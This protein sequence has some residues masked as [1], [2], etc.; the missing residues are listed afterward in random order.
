MATPLPPIVGLPERLD[1]RLRLGPFPSAR[2]ALKF[3]TY[4]A[5]GALLIPFAGAVAW[6]PLVLVAFAVSVWR[7]EGESLDE[8]LLTLAR[9]KWRTL[10]R[11]EAVRRPSS[12]VAA[13]QSSL[14]LSPTRRAAVLKVGGLPLAYLP[15]AEL[16]RRF[17]QFRELLRAVDGTLAF[18][19]TPAPIHANS[20]LPPD[21]VP[22]GAERTAHEGYRELVVLIARRRAVRQVYLAVAC[23]G[24]GIERV[25]RL[26]ASVGVVTERLVGLGLR[27]VRLRDRA[28]ADAARRMGL[29]TEGGAE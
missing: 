6:V 18:R 15:P 23:S 29:S 5:A 25:S 9:W 8:R 10:R 27:P 20:F 4:A 14:G 2:D 24:V 7:P 22:A 13:R 1:R 12:G 17:D 21:P 3:V 11:E 26:E 19:A 28:L 16:A